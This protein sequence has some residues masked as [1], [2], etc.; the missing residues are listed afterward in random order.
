MFDIK[1]AD[2][3]ILNHATLISLFDSYRIV[4][5]DSYLVY[6][7]KDNKKINTNKRC[8]EVWQ[9]GE[10]CK[11][12]ISNSCI[13]EKR[14]II[15]LEVLDGQ[16]FLIAA[17]PITLENKLFSLELISNV[18]DSLVIN[19]AF[20]TQNLDVFDIITQM[21]DM[22][23]RDPYT[24][25]YNK[26]FAEQ[27][28]AKSMLNWNEDHSLFIGVLDIDHFKHVN[29]TY[30]H[31][32][33]DDVLRVL[34]RILDT[35]ATKGNGW[36]SRM[37]GDEFMLLWHNVTAQEARAMAQE[38]QEALVTHIFTKDDVQFTVSVSIGLSQYR[39]E[40]TSW[41]AFFDEADKEMYRVKREKAGNYS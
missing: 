38:L 36:A 7:W 20:H 16:V 3:H 13:Q 29:D 5:I 33:G 17:I 23:L 12:C 27:E 35:Y 11:N 8:Y 1:D 22:A 4:D 34:S 21:N 28:V 40:F 30:G 14:R 39:P 32:K 19:D 6:D 31:M 26:R 18:T 25:L 41:R 37:G 2:A 15:K 9:R 24:G 10:A